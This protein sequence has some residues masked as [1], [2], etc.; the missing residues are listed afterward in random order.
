[1]AK[2]SAQQN[3]L[4]PLMVRVEPE[5]ADGLTMM[6]ARTGR[7]KREAVE[8]ALRAIIEDEFQEACALSGM[9]P[10]ECVA[11]MTHGY[12]EYLRGQR[13]GSDEGG[14]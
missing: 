6:C 7:S 10:S 9:T 14:D 4:R 8:E 1:M 13:R 5:I 11:W 12:I 3:E 2:L